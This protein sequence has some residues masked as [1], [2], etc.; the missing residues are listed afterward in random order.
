MYFQNGGTVSS[1][2]SCFQFQALNDPAQEEAGVSN[3]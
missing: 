3:D 2:V 1:L